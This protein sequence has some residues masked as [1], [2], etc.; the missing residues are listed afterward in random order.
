MKFLICILLLFSL[1]FCDTRRQRRPRSGDVTEIDFSGP[2][3][4]INR[5]RCNRE[6]YKDE[7]KVTLK[8]VLPFVDSRNTGR[9][10]L[11]GQCSERDRLVT[12][13]V[14]GYKVTKNPYCSSRGRWKV[15]LNLTYLA[16][17][18]R[19]VFFR[20]AHGEDSNVV[21]EEVRVAFDCEKGYIPIPSN[22]DF[23]ESS[24][25]VMKYEAKLEDAR[26]VSKPEGRPI[27]RVSY[28][29]A[30][31]LCKNNEGSRYDLM[32]NDQWMNIVHLI[33]EE[34]RNWSYGKSRVREGNMLNCGVIVGSPQ[35]ASTDD[36]DDC[37]GSDCGSKW[38]YKRR[39]HYLP[40]GY[41]IWDMCG[42]VGEMMKD[43]NKNSYNFS[44]HVYKMTT[45]LRKQF[46][47][48]KDYSGGGG[49][50]RRNY[51]WGLGYANMKSSKSLIVRGGQSR[52]AG[53]F[54]VNL[55]YDRD[56]TRLGHDIGF[57]CVYL[58]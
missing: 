35:A 26:A 31:A 44:D 45:T 48:K 11:E 8:T 21:C 10:E 39:T 12:I 53:I 15:F 28:T 46:G 57:R 36:R 20:I 4:R 29:D 55:Q 30:V 32:T 33:E 27:T 54:S 25:C 23:Y 16:T 51:Y 1:S 38:H 41:V 40:S 18:E 49:D 43:E 3:R 9:Y 7:P 14:N 2:D 47:P 5:S 52:S 37:A 22:E 13:E 17:K 42:N 19:N 58:P 34:D 6:P 24:F 50:L 56:R